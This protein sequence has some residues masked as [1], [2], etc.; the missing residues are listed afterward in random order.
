M[1]SAQVEELERTLSTTLRSSTIEWALNLQICDMIQANPY[2][3]PVALSKISSRLRKE[4]PVPVLLALGLLEMLVKNSGLPCARHV[5]DDLIEA[6]VSLVKKRDSWTYSLGR[7]LHKSVGTWLPSGVGIGEDDRKL[8]LQASR[9]VLELFQ[10]WA[11]AFMLQEGELQPIFLAYKVLRKQGHEFPKGEHGAA[12][13]LCLVRGAEE[14]PAYLAGAVQST[15]A[16]P[17]PAPQVNGTAPA[18]IAP[19]PPPRAPAE[20]SRQVEPTPQEAIADARAALDA[21]RAAQAA[22]LVD[23]GV[24]DA[25]RAAKERRAAADA[26][27]TLVDLA[28]SGLDDA[29]HLVVLFEVLEE[30][31]LALA[32]EA[33]RDRSDVETA[34]SSSAP[35]AVISRQPTPDDDF[36]YDDDHLPPPPTDAPPDKE[37][38]ELYD[39]MLARYLQEKEN[40][41]FVADEQA[42]RELALRLSL[43]ENGFSGSLNQMQAP[44]RSSMRMV[45]CGRCQATNQ[46][47]VSVQGQPDDRFIC[48]ACGLTQG[49]PHDRRGMSDLQRRAERAR[50]EAAMR[51]ERHAPPAR[52]ICPR[53]ASE[54]F[55][56]S[57]GLDAE[58]ASSKGHKSSFTSATASASAAASSVANKAVSAA[59]SAAASSSTSSAGM[60]VG[61]NDGARLA[62]LLGSAPEGGAG[63]ASKTASHYASSM[64]RAGADAMSSAAGY[65][66]ASGT[67]SSVKRIGDGAVPSSEY[68]EMG[69][70]CAPLCGGPPVSTNKRSGGKSWKMP[71]K[72]K[73]SG[74][75]TEGEQSLLDRVDV[76]EEWEM[77]RQSDGKSYFYNSR[78]QVSQWQPPEAV[79]Q[80]ASLDD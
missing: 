12:S 5:D 7:N 39:M 2:L 42:D 60:G 16:E 56:G 76:D 44:P 17:S 21:L 52:V 38:Q 55:I 10:L 54:L 49:L 11:D 71:W 8:W 51:P 31:N 36:E 15:A 64:A 50:Q 79:S 80:Y 6:L 14:S 48:Y 29:D 26:R 46:L 58:V 20:P 41:I 37:Q 13:G 35:P 53:G 62:P 47:T 69:D 23:T 4:T 22:P 25:T 34:V 57:N 30:L 67:T 40:E 32:P 63:S 24:P 18:T 74:G 72:S 70:D 45:M 68:A 77:I 28:E 73:R 43:E 66:G 9:K 75:S 33:A 27:A 19:R 59:A 61:S 1:T 65:I 78:T 3:T